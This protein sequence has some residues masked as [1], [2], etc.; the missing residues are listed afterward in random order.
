[1][2]KKQIEV[3]VAKKIWEIASISAKHGNAVM[4]IIGEEAYERVMK[5]QKENIL[6]AAFKDWALT[7]ALSFLYAIYTYYIMNN[8][9]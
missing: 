4:D 5:L 8:I 2:T 3:E 6:F 1:M 9:Y 7:R